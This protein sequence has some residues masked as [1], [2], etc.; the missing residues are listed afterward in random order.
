MPLL[1]PGEGRVSSTE[2]HATDAGIDLTLFRSLEAESRQH[3]TGRL[4][5]SLLEGQDEALR[6][7]LNSQ[8]ELDRLRSE[9]TEEATRHRRSFLRRMLVFL[10]LTF[11]AVVAVAIALLI[12]PLIFALILIV[13]V[14]FC[15][16][17]SFLYV[18][19][20]AK[21]HVQW[22]YRLERETEELPS[23]RQHA[24]SEFRRLSTLYVQYLHWAEI[25]CEALHRPLGSA[26]T[27]ENQEQSNPHKDVS[28]QILS[29]V[30]GNAVMSAR[31]RALL[32]LRVACNAAERGWMMRSFG[33]RRD[34]WIEEY[35]EIADALSDQLSS[36]PEAD[37]EASASVIFET[38]P[39]DMHENGREIRMPLADFATQYCSGQ[40]SGKCRAE[41]SA[42]LKSRLDN[43]TAKL[44][45]HIETTAKGSDVVSL[46]EFLGDWLTDGSDFDCTGYVNRETMGGTLDHECW[47][48]LSEVVQSREAPFGDSNIRVHPVLYSEANPIVASF[49]LE[50][51]DPVLVEHCRLIA[52]RPARSGRESEDLPADFEPGFG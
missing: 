31:E 38:S 28:T 12:A 18:L 32:Q 52:F 24:I 27:A 39:F 16:V 6:E 4:A 33:H 19:A 44:V 7:L 3:L 20:I 36:A 29:L 14:L 10:S 47:I 30:I 48:G 50:V 40:Y 17:K 34:E 35:E 49:R 26:Y 22:K 51:S 42:E 45:D 41:I 46:E 37:A 23:R 43:R 9:S 11:L 8:Q 21:D 1:Q 5:W 13:V 25:L 15:A 2:N